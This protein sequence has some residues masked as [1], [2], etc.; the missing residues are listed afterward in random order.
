[1]DRDGQVTAPASAAE[2][3][4][5]PGVRFPPLLVFVAGFGAALLLDR[6]LGFEIDGA[7]A[8][9][10]QL[11]IGTVLVAGGLTLVAWAIQTLARSHTTVRPD[12][13]ARAFVT[14][15]PYRFTRNP[16]YVGLTFIYLGSAVLSNLAWP[17]VLLPLVLMTMSIAVIGREE[18]HLTATF[19]AEYDAYCRRVHRW[20]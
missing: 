4:H 13:P 3:S 6:R 18:R 1:M 9:T 17:L 12:R 16:I 2:F 15:G 10:M 19:G 5:G 14:A 7:G 11:G 20:L 8:S